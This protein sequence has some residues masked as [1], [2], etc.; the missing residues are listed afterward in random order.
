M[1]LHSLQYLRRVSRQTDVKSPISLP[2]LCQNQIKK[3]Q[4]K[5]IANPIHQSIGRP[6]VIPALSISDMTWELYGSWARRGVINTM[7]G[8]FVTMSH[9]IDVTTVG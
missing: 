6:I 3:N 2:F 4:K 1:R 8:G 5:I 9:E 7:V